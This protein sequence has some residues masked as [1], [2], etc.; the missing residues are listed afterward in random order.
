MTKF[1][2]KHKLCMNESHKNARKKIVQQI[3]NSSQMQLM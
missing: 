2:T 3:E 1:F